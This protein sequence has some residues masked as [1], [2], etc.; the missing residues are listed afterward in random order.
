MGDDVKNLTHRK[1]QEN[2][3]QKYSDFFWVK[4]EIHNLTSSD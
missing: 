4:F 2:L 1:N 3:C